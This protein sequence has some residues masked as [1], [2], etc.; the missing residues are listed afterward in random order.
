M[1]MLHAHQLVRAD[2]IAGAAAVDINFVNGDVTALRN[3]AIGSGFNFVLD[4]GLFHRL[5]DSQRAVMGGEVTAV[6]APGT[7]LLMIAWMPGRR[8]PL[9]RGASHADIEAAFPAWTVIAED[10]I[11]ASALPSPLKNAGPR[12]YRLQRASNAD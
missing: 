11:P 8:P 6:T 4:F 2:C 9:P 12:F 7:T 5:N 1:R 10:A 3:L